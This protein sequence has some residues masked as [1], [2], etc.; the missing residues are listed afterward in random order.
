MK[1]LNNLDKEKI[2][3]IVMEAQYQ[4]CSVKKIYKDL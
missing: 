3:S 4:T 2:I 1:A